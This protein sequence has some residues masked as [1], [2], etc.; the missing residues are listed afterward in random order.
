MYW[1]S[2]Y[3]NLK[4]FYSPTLGPDNVHIGTT[5]CIRTEDAEVMCLC[6]GFSLEVE[7]R[8][9]RFLSPPSLVISD[10]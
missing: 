9:G 10:V 2:L 1:K 5:I 7:G 3:S 4:M 8:N 6:V